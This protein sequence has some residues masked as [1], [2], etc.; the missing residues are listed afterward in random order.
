MGAPP[1]G[2]PGAAG[3]TA[4]LAVLLAAGASLLLRLPFLRVPLTADEAGYAYVAYWLEQGLVLYRDLWF[5]RPQAIFGLYAAVFALVG[6]STEAIRLGAAA[7]NAATV[8]ALAALADRLCGRRAAVIAAWVYAAASVSPALE[9]FTAN[10]ELFM[11]LPAVVA[12]LLAARGRPT[13]AG[14]ALGL[15]TAVKPTALPTALPPALLL[16]C[17]PLPA[18]RGAAPP[19]GPP[20][21]GRIDARGAARLSAGLALGLTPFV[22]EGMR[23]DAV[24]FWYAVVGFRV[25]QHSAFAAGPRFFD[26]LWQALPVAGP[27]LLPA[28]LLAAGW[29][30]KGAWRTP[31]GGALLAYLAGA[32][33]GSALGGYW[34]WHYFIGVLPP[35]AVIAGQA[36][37]ALGRRRRAAAP[38]ALA[39]TTAVA[40]LVNLRLVG[41]SPEQTSWL[42]YGDRSYLAGDAIAAYL[43][44]RT[45]PAER[46]YVAFAQP[47]IYY[48]SGR[49]SAGR[50]LYW[51]EINRVPGAFEAVLEALDDPERHP[52][53]VLGVQEELERAGRAAPFWERVRARYR[54][55]AVIGGFVLYRFFGLALPDLPSFEPDGDGDAA[56]SPH[57]SGDPGDPGD[58][59]G[60]A[61]G[62]P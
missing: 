52:T 17:W 4:V 11:N 45:G 19:A 24:A 54:P 55:E 60:P 25:Q 40:L 58:P 31:A 29:T 1:A 43:R 12:V 42:V 46:I 2:R 61:D 51:T 48:L 7:Y 23:T 33:A 6:R 30:L 36:L 27:A 37:T 62:A 14:I 13:L 10:G 26:E 34:Y 56:S 53:Y 5:D 59:A 3:A 15:A 32:L 57:P 47:A 50:H 21:P 18:R 49:R 8:L 38:F 41:P 20:W 22:G 9:G 28:W 35:L 39:A 16:A 44:E